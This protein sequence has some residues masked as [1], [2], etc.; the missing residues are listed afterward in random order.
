MEMIKKYRR[1]AA[2]L[3]LVFLAGGCTS[4]GTEV[5]NPPNPSESVIGKRLLMIPEIG[6]EAYQV[7]F[8]DEDTALADQLVKSDLEAV[9]D[10]QGVSYTIASGE[11]SFAASFSNGRSI[12]VLFE[13]DDGQFVALQM[14]VDGEA[15]AAS[16][17]V[18]GS[19]PPAAA[20]AVTISNRD[21]AR[22]VLQGLST[23]QK[24]DAVA[25]GCSAS[26]SSFEGFTEGVLCA[27]GIDLALASDAGIQSDIDNLEG[28]DNSDFLDGDASGATCP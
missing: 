7:T 28:V 17:E 11:L 5:V 16:F 15:V 6:D 22:T 4:K 19:V 13:V 23:A 12:N 25:A 9:L 10:T 20:C 3:F 14:E 21:E 24:E 27:L 26:T 18:T 8:Y 1:L 2:F